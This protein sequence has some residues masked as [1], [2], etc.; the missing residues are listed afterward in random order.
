[1]G[2]ESKSV[3]ATLQEVFNT[4]VSGS[5]HLANEIFSLITNA[6]TGDGIAHAH[7]LAEL[8]KLRSLYQDTGVSGDKTLE[9]IEDAID[10]L[11]TDEGKYA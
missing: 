6:E 2:K 7:S 4:P 8:Q 3:E 5:V 11:N 9:L 10:L 1:V